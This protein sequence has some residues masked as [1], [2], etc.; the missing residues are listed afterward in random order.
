MEFT[1]IFSFIKN[2][3]NV[4]H[5]MFYFV[6]IFAFCILLYYQA[7]YA[8]RYSALRHYALEASDDNEFLSVLQ[9][10]AV[11]VQG[12]WVAKTSL[13][14]KDP[15]ESFARDYILFLFSREPVIR[16]SV[17]RLPKALSDPMKK[18]LNIFAV[19]RPSLDDWKFKQPTDISFL[20]N[21][22]DIVKGQCQMW[23]TRGKT[24]MGYLNKGGKP[25]PRDGNNTSNATQR[26]SKMVPK[27]AKVMNFDRTP[28]KTASRTTL[29]P[30][31]RDALP[32][33]LQKVFQNQKVCRCGSSSF[34]AVI[35]VVLPTTAILA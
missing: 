9:H 20:K 18:F 31:T 33:A 5:V 22:P 30:E 25:N 12:C 1:F 35:L 34:P 6:L 21:H 26:Q 16:K 17:L 11:L 23:E 8:H 14:L 3:Y 19:E 29:S 2:S 32:K 4:L 28:A 10:N 27:E 15:S 7:P 24:I 13:L